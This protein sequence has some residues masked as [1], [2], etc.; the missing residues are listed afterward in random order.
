[1]WSR[2]VD[3]EM[4]GANRYAFRNTVAVYRGA[5]P[6]RNTVAHTVEG[7]P[8]KMRGAYRGGMPWR[9]ADNPILLSPRHVDY[10]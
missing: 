1:M 8:L 9:N 4:N 6:W 5:M 3:C 2:I 7:H 10:K